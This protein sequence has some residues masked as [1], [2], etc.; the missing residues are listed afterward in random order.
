[1]ENEASPILTTVVGS[2]PVPAWLPGSP[3][4]SS[5]RDATLVVVR[6]QELA[7]IDV[8]ADGELYRY[9]LNHPE[10]NGMIDYFVGQMS[11]IRTRLSRQEE[12]EFHGLA[13]MAYRSQPAGVV[14]GSLGPGTLNLPRASQPLLEL[15][16][17]RTK[18]TVTSPYMLARVLLDRFY[19]DLR[20]LTMAIAAVLAEQV[21]EL[22]TDVVQVDEANLTGNPQDG[23]WVADAI[24]LLLDAVKGAPAVHLCF[25]NYGGQTIQRGHYDQL[26]AFMNAL[27]ADHVVLEMA[28]QEPQELEYLRELD[29]RIG[30]GL[31]VIDIKDNQV[32]TP[33]QVAARIERAEKVLGAGRL[34]YVHPD[35]GFWMLPRFVADLKMRALVKGRDLFLGKS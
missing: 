32:E 21:A 34:R 7:G 33:E 29:S 24:N 11:G 31:G 16:R 25:G 8:V 35:C 19:Q 15:A 26:L 23:L 1:M 3:A 14:Q 30:L 20:S 22:E 28:R 6:T 27:H 2:Y 18:F 10:T 17:H 12:Q 9:D 4:R 5:L 13:G